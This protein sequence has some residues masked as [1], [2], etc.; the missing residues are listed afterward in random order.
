MRSF[1]YHLAAIALSVAGVDVIGAEWFSRSWVSPIDILAGSAISVIGA[2]PVLLA[3][4]AF[5]TYAF[6]LF[7][8]RPLRGLFAGLCASAMM[9]A[10]AAGFIALI[11]IGA[12]APQS[13]GAQS[14]W[15]SVVVLALI[16]IAWCGV[17]SLIT[18]PILGVKRG[19]TRARSSTAEGPSA[20]PIRTS[21]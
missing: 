10:L 17:A 9:G 19:R 16:C 2:I 8:N 13:P 14:F 5:F 21:P 20:G 7:L 15:L 3:Y 18:Q 1:L 4:S 12:A 11:S 6:W